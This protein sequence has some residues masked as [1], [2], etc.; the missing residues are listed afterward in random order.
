MS[1]LLIVVCSLVKNMLLFCCVYFWFVNI[2]FCCV[3]FVRFVCLLCLLSCLM[4]L[5]VV[6][7]RCCMFEFVVLFVVACYVCSLF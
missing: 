7:S 4:C 2:V 5:I 1:L 3:V 6:V